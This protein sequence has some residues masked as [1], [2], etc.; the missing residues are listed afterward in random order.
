[1]DLLF[2]MPSF[3]HSFLHGLLWAWLGVG[4]KENVF[5]IA[6]ASF[7]K[8]PW[9]KTLWLNYEN[10]LVEWFIKY[11]FLSPSHLSGLL[12]RAVQSLDA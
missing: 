1:M 10:A 7:R 2:Y 5:E 4:A 9:V 6:V 3:F 12:D 11:T 8:V